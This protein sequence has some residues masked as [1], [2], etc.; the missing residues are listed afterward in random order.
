MKKENNLLSAEEQEKVTALQ[1]EKQAQIYGYCG[2]F[3]TPEKLQE[4]IDKYV[5]GF[6]KSDR[7]MALT[8]AYGIVNYYAVAIAT[9]DINREKE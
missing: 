7:A 6:N 3:Y 5:N 1:I 4:H 8:L 9:D 2:M